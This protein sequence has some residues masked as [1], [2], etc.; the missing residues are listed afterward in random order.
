MEWV[1]LGRSKMGMLQWILSYMG[2]FG[3]VLKLKTVLQSNVVV[4]AVA[5][6]II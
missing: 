4:I 3:S 2:D 1:W 5:S 6:L